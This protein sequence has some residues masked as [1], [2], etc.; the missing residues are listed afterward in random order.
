MWAQTQPKRWRRDDVT[1]DLPRVCSD[2]C[3]CCCCCTREEHFMLPTDKMS[4][5]EAN[6]D[7]KTHRTHAHTNSFCHFLTAFVLIVINACDSGRQIDRVDWLLDRTPTAVRT[8]KRFHF[9][10]TNR[11]CILYFF[12]RKKTLNF[13]LYCSVWWLPLSKLPTHVN[14]SRSVRAHSG[15][16]Q[17][18]NESR[19]ASYTYAHRTLRTQ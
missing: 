13:F 7:G 2:H 15:I 6:V 9:V 10:F 17:C 8:L 18:I 12:Q 16:T 1:L 11:F 14:R 5:A 4:F 3:C 19:V